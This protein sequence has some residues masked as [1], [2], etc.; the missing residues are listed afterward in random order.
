MIKAI[1]Y[2]I[3]ALATAAFLWAESRAEDPII[4]LRF[5]KQRTFATVM[6]IALLFGAAFLGAI[7]YLTQF[8]Q[9]VFDATATTAGL[10]LLP[11]IA[12]LMVSSIATGQIVSRTGKYK[13]MMVSGFLIATI[14]ILALVTLTPSSPFWHEAVMMVFAGLGLGMGMPIMNLAVQNEVEQHDLGV[15]T[16]SSQLFRGLGSTVGTAVLGSALTFGVATNLGNF[17]QDPYIQTLKQS[18]AASQIV[19]KGEVSVDSALTINTPDVRSQIKD[20]LNKSLVAQVGLPA[21]AKE[22][23]TSDFTT[24]QNAFKDK[25]VGAFAGSLHTIFYISAALMAVATLLAATVVEKPLRGGVD[26]TPGMA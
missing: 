10:M 15:A 16:A 26:D 14:S 23:I 8:N 24:K 22:K 11:M 25:V 2:G 20:G 13:V 1:L 9:Q 4:P 18:P 3:T 7:L 17:Q 5:F 12:G 21:P 6:V 19:G